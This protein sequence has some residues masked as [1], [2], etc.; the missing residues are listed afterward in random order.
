[1]E[2]KNKSDLERDVKNLQNNYCYECRYC[3]KSIWIE[4]AC[5][6]LFPVLFVIG[7]RRKKQQH[8][9]HSIKVKF[10]LRKKN[11]TSKNIKE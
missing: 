2:K 6:P 4:L 3:K 5:L 11:T 8:K 9:A 7:I 10:Y 1:V